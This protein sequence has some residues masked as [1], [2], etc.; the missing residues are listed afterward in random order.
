MDART[1]TGPVGKSPELTEA[2][3]GPTPLKAVAM[4]HTSDSDLVVARAL[5]GDFAATRRLVRGDWENLLREIFNAI[6]KTD[7]L[8][9]QRPSL[10]AHLAKLP[11]LQEV[12]DDP[13]EAVKTWAVVGTREVL[14]RPIAYK[15]AYKPS[16][17]IFIS[18]ERAVAAVQ[19]DVLTDVERVKNTFEASNADV[20]RWTGVSGA[21]TSL[22]D[23]G[24]TSP[25]PAQAARLRD[26]VD[27]A[28]TF[29]EDIVADRIISLFAST[30]V[31]ALEG[32]TYRDALDLGV[33]PRYLA[34]VLR[35][36]VGDPV[37]TDVG[38]EWARG[39]HPKAGDS[40][41]EVMRFRG[42]PPVP[43]AR[44]KKPSARASRV[45]DRLK[46]RH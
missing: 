5:D 31:P 18:F 20:G 36:A 1:S 40:L 45:L 15:L 38:L 16:V 35:F 28:A 44:Q 6:G 10:I 14:G 7:V 42:E 25:A 24:E 11:A 9:R 43:P 12:Y 17:K 34:D 2:L 37:Q 29:E 13:C 32:H 22:W 46:S 26:L 3:L 30:P 23:R 39:A 8:E 21:A 27:F 33:P 4:L 19:G 41:L